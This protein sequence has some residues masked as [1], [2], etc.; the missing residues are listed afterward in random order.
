MA[1]ITL[2]SDW[3]QADWYVAAVKGAIYSALPDATIVDITHNIEPFDIRSAAFILG[4]CYKNFPKGTIH[5]VA[6]ETEESE[7]NPHIVVKADGQYFIGTDNDFF[8]LMLGNDA[9]YEAVYNDVI[10]DSDYFTF[11]TRDRFVKTAVMLAKGAPMSEIGKPY[12]KI[13]EKLAF[14]PTITA[15]SIHGLVIFVDA[16]ENLITN[17]TQEL[18]ERVRAGRNFVVKLR[19]RSYYEINTI[20]KSYQDVGIPDIVALFGTHGYLEIAINH[21]KAAS[22]LGVGRDLP[23]DIVFSL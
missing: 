15:D 6:V 13:K 4:N 3:G 1:I 8:S 9:T 19:Y 18:F 16:Y 7:E 12:P 21:G 23:V 2:I 11:A 14:L 17:I 10:Q 20:G 22:L 5:I